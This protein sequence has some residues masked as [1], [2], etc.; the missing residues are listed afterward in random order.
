MDPKTC[1]DCVE[2]NGKI[3]E[4]GEKPD[5]SPPLHP[6]CRCKIETMQAIHAGDATKDGKNGADYWLKN[7]G[8][9]PKYYINKHDLEKYGWKLGDRPSKFAKGRMLTMGVYDNEDGHLPQKPGRIWFEADINYYDGR[10]NTHRILW[11]DDG[12]IFVT[13]DHY[14]TFLEII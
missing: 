4:M 13:Y 12:L 6:F 1:T 7:F 10:R 14:R 9:L 3:Y 11:S 2:I 5:P 8:A